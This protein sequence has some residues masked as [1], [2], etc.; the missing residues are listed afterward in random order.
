MPRISLRKIIA[1]RPLRAKLIFNATSGKHDESP[2][3]LANILNEMQNQQ[4]LPEVYTVREDSQIE[5]VVHNALKDG[6]KLFVVAGGDGTIDSVVGSLVGKSATLGII[7]TGTRNNLAFNLGIPDGIAEAVALLRDGRRLKIDVGQVRGG[8]TKRWFLEAASMGLLSDLYPVADDIQHGN[9]AQIGGFLSTLVT[10]VPSN[11]RLTLDGHRPFN[12]TA[13]LVLIANMPFVGPRFQI[14]TN[15]SFRDNRL[16]VFV[17]SDM[18]K[19]NLVTYV[20]QSTGSE[21]VTEDTRI[22]HYRAKHL[23]IDSDPPMTL[24]ADGAPLGEGRL[25]AVIRRHALTVIAGAV[26]GGEPIA[27]LVIDPK[28]PKAKSNG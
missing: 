26:L 5:E 11:L 4:I 10:A 25:T 16:D 24:L 20:M 23:T 2:H 8:R 3:Q 27:S 17:F 18:S 6:I 22:K 7:P 12:T 15:V 13:H 19:L 28:A 21:G 14:A 1:R 9:L